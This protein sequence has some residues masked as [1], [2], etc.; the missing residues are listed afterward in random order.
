VSQA[1]STT[2]VS[3]IILAGGASSRFGFNKA[4]LKIGDLSLVERVVERLRSVVTDIVLVTNLPDQFGF[5]DL[6]MTGDIY[7]G[8]GTLGGLHA[9]LSAIHTEYGLVVG[10]DM[11]FLNTDLLRYMVSVRAQADVVMPRLGHYYEPLH[12][13]YARQCLPTI[14]QSIEAGQRRV[15]RA[16]DGLHIK[17]VDENQVARYDPHHHS[18]FNVNTPK[19]LRQLNEMLEQNP[20]A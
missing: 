1:D 6:T 14:E 18:F 17:Y 7:R 12:A 13:V 15:L 5:L 10:C 3:G 16:C 2:G 11:P 19:D 20:E 8:I 9:G 4:L